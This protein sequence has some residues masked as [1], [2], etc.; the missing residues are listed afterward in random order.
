MIFQGNMC[1]IDRVMRILIGC[2][3]LYVGFIDPSLIGI[4]SQIL[5]VVLGI[6]G[7]INIGAAFL[8]F[9]PVYSIAGISSCR[10]SDTK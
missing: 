1:P 10:N 2:A 5:G 9:C 7:L 4:S 8:G 6:V 3:L